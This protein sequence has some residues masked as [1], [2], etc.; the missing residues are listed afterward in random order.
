MSLNELKRW[1]M[2]QIVDPTRAYG[3]CACPA[4]S[5]FSPGRPVDSYHID[6]AEGLAAF[7]RGSR[8]R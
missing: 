3:H 8:A 2:E 6:T 5:E 4:P 1:L 7:V